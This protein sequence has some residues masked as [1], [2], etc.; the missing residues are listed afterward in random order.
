[1]DLHRHAR[2]LSLKRVE[3]G[4]VQVQQEGVAV[5]VGFDL[6]AG[7]DT[8]T[9]RPDLV[10]TEPALLELVE[11]VAQGTLADAPHTARRQLQAAVASCRPRSR[12][13]MSPAFSRICA[14]WRTR[15]SCWRASG[16][17]VC[18]SRPRSMSSSLKLPR[19]S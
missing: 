12:R 6:L 13:P 14:I 7:L 3:E 2:A 10:L 17:S 8:L 18:S 5:L 1:L 16:P 9:S 4:L 19:S 11:D 15:S